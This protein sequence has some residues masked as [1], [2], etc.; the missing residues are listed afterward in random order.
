MIEISRTL[1]LI[2]GLFA[3]S[4]LVTDIAIIVILCLVKKG[5]RLYFGYIREE[6]EISDDEGD[7]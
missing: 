2:L 5:A 4:G 6:D 1:A 3:L 7:C